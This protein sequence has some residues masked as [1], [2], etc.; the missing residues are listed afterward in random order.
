MN[1]RHAEPATPRTPLLRSALSAL[2]S[3][4]ALWLLTAFPATRLFDQLTAAPAASAQPAPPR[5]GTP[6][7]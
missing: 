1:S 6:H 7:S 3:V 5:A 4:A 2:L